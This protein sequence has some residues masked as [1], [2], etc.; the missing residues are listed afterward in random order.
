MSGRVIKTRWI[1]RNLKKI[2]YVGDVDGCLGLLDGK[3]ACRSKSGG[4]NLNSG[5]AMGLELPLKFQEADFNLQLNNLELVGSDCV[6]RQCSGN[7]K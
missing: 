6:C 5:L 1:K 2:Y 7:V 4:L 3:W